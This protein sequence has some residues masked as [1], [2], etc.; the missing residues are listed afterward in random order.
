MTVAS[1]KPAV[2]SALLTLSSVR[3]DAMVLAVLWS[4]VL[5][6]NSTRIP[7]VARRRLRTLVSG[8]ILS[9]LTSSG[10]MEGPAAWAIA[11]MKSLCFCWSKSLIVMGRDKTIFTVCVEALVC[12]KHGPP[13]GPVKPAL[14]E[15]SVTV[16][17]VTGEVESEGQ[18]THL[19]DPTLEYPPA[20]QSEQEEDEVGE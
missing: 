6:L 8:S 14:Q 1:G 11:A 12:F 20:L 9:M 5:M 18:E 17:L 2:F 4:V 15:Q 10:A 16:V 19:D 13:A 7:S 3:L